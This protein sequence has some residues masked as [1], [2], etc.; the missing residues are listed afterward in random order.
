MSP[1]NESTN[2]EFATFERYPECVPHAERV[3]KDK[4]YSLARQGKIPVYRL[5]GRTA[6]CVKVDE[7]R[8]I[9]ANLSARGKIRRGYGSFGPDAVVRDLSKVAGQDFE[10]LE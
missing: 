4:L 1:P 5:P 2:P 9:L 6:A 7:A 8:A 3:S 10:V